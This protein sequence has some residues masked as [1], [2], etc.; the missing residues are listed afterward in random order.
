MVD[1]AKVNLYG[2]QMGSIRWDSGRNT[3]LFV[4][5]WPLIAK[6]CEVPQKMIDAI[7]T[8]MKLSI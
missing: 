3:V 8:E 2:Q 4:S 7:F 1:I 5:R 6:E